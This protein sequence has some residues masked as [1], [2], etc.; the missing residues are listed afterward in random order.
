M[1]RTSLKSRKVKIIVWMLLF[2][3]VTEI[4]YPT[5]A[6]A[7][8]G[9]PSQPEV[10]SF[11]P[12]GTSDM[13]DVFSGDFTYNIPLM[14]VGGYPVNISYHSGINT[15]QEA[16]WTGLGWNINPGSI[17]RN[18]RGLPDDFNGDAVTTEFNRKNNITVGVDV[19]SDVELAGYKFLEALK[20]AGVELTVSAGMNYNN[21]KGIGL[22]IGAS[23][24]A[25]LAE[26]NSGTL[27][28]S[29]GIN[30]SSQDGLSVNPSLS[31]SKENDVVHETHV[32]KSTKTVSIGLPYNSREGLKSVTVS[33]SKGVSENRL[34]LRHKNHGLQKKKFGSTKSIG[35]GISFASPSYS[36]TAGTPLTNFSASFEL[37]LGFTGLALLADASATG[38]FNIQYVSDKSI[39]NPG[40]GYLYAHEASKA[41][42]RGMHDFNREKDGS[43]TEHIP[44][45]ALAQHTYDA[46][47]V[48]GQGVGGMYMPRRGDIGTVFDAYTENTGAGFDVGGID[49]GGGAF[50]QGG[51]N[52]KL[53]DSYTRTGR[54]INRNETTGS[55]AFKKS[56]G[57]DLYEPSY[58]M[59]AGEMVPETDTMLFKA[60]G[61]FSPVR[62]GLRPGDFASTTALNSLENNDESWR[63]NISRNTRNERERRNQVIHTL[64]SE[65]ASVA[66]LDKYIKFYTGSTPQ[67][68]RLDSIPRTNYPG[69]HISELSV[70]RPDGMRYV[71]G[72]P[73]YNTKQEEVTFAIDTK[74]P[75]ACA[76]GLTGFSAN[77]ATTDNN[78]GGDHFYQKSIMPQYAH[79]YLLTAV[80]SPDYVD[81]TGNGL[82]EDDLGNYTKFNYVR[83]AQGY[84]WRI[85]FNQASHNE[86]MKSDE[87][88]DK[89][90][91]LYGEKEIWYLA[92]IETRTHLAIFH[93]EN[94]ADSYGS[95]GY[96]GGGIDSSK[97]LQKL[98]KISLYAKPE[99]QSLGTGASPIKEVHFEYSYEL[100]K[101][102]TG[103]LE[104][105]DGSPVDAGGFTN[106]GGKLTLKKV[107]FTYGKSKKGKLS[108]YVF[109][110]ADMNHDGTQDTNFPYHIKGYDRWGNYK[111]VGP[112][113]GCYQNGDLSTAEF[114]YVDQD[115]ARTSSYSAAW[116]MTSI[117]LPSGGTIEVDYEADDYAFVQ[118]KRAMQMMTIEGVSDDK[119]GSNLKTYLFDPPGADFETQTPQKFIF[120]RL[121]NPIVA[122]NPTAADAL[123]K[124][125]YFQ[126]FN[127]NPFKYLYFKFMVNVA[128]EG[129]AQAYEYVPGY[130]EY[131]HH[132]VVTDQTIQ[133]GGQSHY[134][135]AYVKI[136]DVK[137]SNSLSGNAH[138]VSKAAWQ[139]ARLYLPY[140]AFKQDKLGEKFTLRSIVG[141]LDAMATTLAQVVIGFNASMRKRRCGNEFEPSKSWIRVYSPEYKKAGGGTR[142]KRLQLVDNWKQMTGKSKYVDGVF[143]QEYDYTIYDKENAQTMSSG[144]ATYEPLLGGEE[145]P[146]RQPDIYDINRALAPSNEFYLELPYG[147]SM[148]PGPS[149]GYSKV[150][151]KNLTAPGVERNGSGSVVHEFYTARDYPTISHKTDPDFIVKKP[152]IA[153]LVGYTKSSMDVSQGFVIELNDM[154]GKPKSQ[155]VYQEGKQEAISGVEYKYKVSATD[156][157]RLDNTVKVVYPDGSIQNKMIGI[158]YDVTVDSRNS[159]T[160]AGSVEFS[161]NLNG[162]WA[163]LFPAAIGAIYPN[164][165]ES[166]MIF[167]SMSVTKVINR[168]G[169]LD[170]TIAY[171][172]GSKVSTENLLYDA[173]TGG[174]LLTGTVNQY[175]DPIYSFT[176]PAH[177][178]YEGMGLAYKNIGLEVKGRSIES[179]SQYLVPGD[180][181]LVNEGGN[182]YT[183]WVVAKSPSLDVQTRFGVTVNTGT[184]FTSVKV[185]RSG[186]RN[187][188]STPIGSV[189]SLKN[190]INGSK[191]ILA[192]TPDPLVRD[193]YSSILNAEAVVFEDSWPTYCSCEYENLDNYNPYVAG[194]KGNWR[195]KRSYLHLS[196]R[197]QSRINE[198]VNVRRD[199]TMGSFSPFWE[200][201][202]G[203]GWADDTTNWTW[204]S[205]ITVF[206][207]RGQELE[208][209]DALNRYSGALYGY[210]ELL[211]TAV[212]NNARYREIAFDGFEDY[213]F[214]G[215]AENHFSFR[216]DSALV[217]KR[218]SHTGRYSIGIPPGSSI[219]IERVIENCR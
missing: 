2:T 73:A 111:P 41:G 147:E 173:E 202:A 206:S 13:V 8:T 5:A 213:K 148:F 60:M 87:Y 162:F 32:G 118:D 190:P 50:F 69:H 12:V 117:D 121:Q 18:M 81:R 159:H 144:V 9:G 101:P 56:T 14:D 163:I 68:R 28:G 167:N 99:Y 53:N 84:K 122:G 112:N 48:A 26:T 143:G 21:Y 44:A 31:F 55:L 96:N 186:R 36:P 172:L 74:T 161:G 214:H 71:Y 211:P 104:N 63:S 77:Q 179:I 39:N 125:K 15:D 191:L 70:F 105:N 47:S 46:Y 192:Q 195:A 175:D 149:V 58:F 34:V 134:Y 182:K 170:K 64:T 29:L 128:G 100:C 197:K 155:W 86:G 200:Y 42:A 210:S 57:N 205:E 187:Q 215:C 114:P 27:T 82:T 157:T 24:S 67:T 33:A 1:M 218:N 107:Y 207:P 174:V 90:S 140:V 10:Q 139:F 137:V 141:A 199:G 51:G 98:R 7:L 93:L 216:K 201:A 133:I 176:Y 83:A 79:S 89:A 164:F 217:E 54:W 185:I 30:L 76:T 65:E 158:D 127:G 95:T 142:V 146:W 88:D 108:P 109:N 37:N 151:V 52:I 85:P 131:D 180:E 165:T 66:G 135:L 75:G 193:Y 49:I 45:I 208:N 110:Y 177:W 17:T 16:S 189:V 219:E 160:Y 91:F 11:E 124:K 61:E 188:Q 116:C 103:R 196:S 178:V 171:D 6:Y 115:Y 22:S 209:K 78:S 150:T 19:S 181:L 97:P 152:G 126:D 156:S 129:E 166:N 25:S 119:T 203:A 154:H 212:A 106:E 153:Q 59:Q 145:N 35:A 38:Y 194:L 168:Y 198:N 132:G 183:A 92:S 80:V 62:V 184:A 102:A 23:P 130:M 136:K 72:I 204:T 40:Y 94:R 4:F 20:K 169:I 138:P 123:V 3:F 113:V 43:F 120:F